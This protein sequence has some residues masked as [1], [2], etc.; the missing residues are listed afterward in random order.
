MNIPHLSEKVDIKELL[1]RFPLFLIPL[2]VII[3]LFIRGFSPLYV[4]FWASVVMIVL[5]LIRKSARPSFI[6]LVRGLTNGAK[7]GSQIAVS[8]AFL[9]M[10]VKVITMTGLGVV[11]PRVMTELCGGD[12]VLLLIFTGVVSIILG[13]GLPAATSYIMVAVVMAPALL[14]MGLPVLTAHFFAFYFCNFSYITP[15]VALACVFA[16]KLAEARYIKTGIEAVKV[17]MAG[18]IIPFMIIWCP[19][20]LLNFSEPVVL[21]MMKLIAC[22]VTLL[23]LQISIVG[24]Y[25]SPLNIVE[26]AMSGLSS[27]MFFLSIYYGNILSFIMGVIIFTGL[28]FWQNLK[29]KRVAIMMP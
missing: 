12:L 10:M 19:V 26:R 4:G 14:K 6:Q 28:T 17:G 22:F 5:S 27:I 21:S 24:Y 3:L 8:C 7:L 9:G 23:G 15:P 25:F 2:L 29:K 18:F 1:Y 20:L 16:S 13:M 11:L